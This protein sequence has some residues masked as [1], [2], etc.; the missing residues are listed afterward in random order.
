MICNFAAM[1]APAAI[2][3][4][5]A[6]LSTAFFLPAL[7]AEFGLL[8]YEVVGH[9][10]VAYD[11]WFC[12]LLNAT[13]FAI[14]G[15]MMGDMRAMA[16]LVA[17]SGIQNNVMIDAG[18]RTVKLWVIFNVL[19]VINFAAAWVAASLQFIEHL[20][21]FMLLRLKYIQIDADAFVSSDLMTLIVLLVRN[22]YRK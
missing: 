3:D 1:V 2:G 7:V 8:R 21:M 13:T 20:N 14:L 18:V 4:P 5:C 19:A 16:I 11:F 12:T 17:W 6:L 10:L 15:V 22:A 9:L